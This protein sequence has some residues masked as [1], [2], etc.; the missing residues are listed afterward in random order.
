MESL[1]QSLAL[2]SFNHM[3][4]SHKRQHCEG[5]AGQSSG[6]IFYKINRLLLFVGYVDVKWVEYPYE[7]DAPSL[8][9]PFLLGPCLMPF[10]SK[11]SRALD[12]CRLSDVS[13]T[14]NPHCAELLVSS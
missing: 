13:G 6:V 7:S 3:M 4:R 14:H 12:S 9:K 11:Y 10:I 2:Y 8:S 5:I 1:G